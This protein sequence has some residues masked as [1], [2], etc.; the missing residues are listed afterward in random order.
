MLK[1]NSKRIIAM[2]MLVLT[3]FSTLS[4]SVFATEISSANIE[5][6]GDVEWHLQYWND[7][8]NVWS[9]VTT[10]YTTYN[11]G[12][13]SYP[14]YCVNREYPGVGEL[15]GYTVDVNASVTDVLG[16]VQIWRTIINGFPYKSAG[17]L[18]LANDLEAFQATKQAVY[19]IWF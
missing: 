9:Y 6:N 15:D 13:R 2:L 11:E 14:A 17:E 7:E 18:G 1:V 5:N 3:L 19:C 10:T 4:P 16:N 12:G 8:K